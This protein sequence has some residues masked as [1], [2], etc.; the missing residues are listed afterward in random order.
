MTTKRGRDYK[1]IP[2][3]SKKRQKVETDDHI[4]GHGAGRLAGAIVNADELD[5]KA[6]ELPDRFEDAE[7]F[8]GLEEVEGVDIVRPYGTR[9]AKFNVV[10]F[11]QATWLRL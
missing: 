5:W 2:L 1:D 6:V 8:F 7:G 11:H 4:A 9:R 3:K 10:N